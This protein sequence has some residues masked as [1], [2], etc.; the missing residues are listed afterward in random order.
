VPAAKVTVH[1]TCPTNA[2][3]VNW[4]TPGPL[5]WKLWFVAWSLTMIV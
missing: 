4:S 1:V 3:V 5:R 2:S